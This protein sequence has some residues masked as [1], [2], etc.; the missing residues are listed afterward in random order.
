MTLSELRRGYVRRKGGAWVPK[1][2]RTRK[3]RPSTSVHAPNSTEGRYRRECLSGIAPECIHYESETFTIT[4]VCRREYTPDWVVAVPGFPPFYHEVKG[5]YKL[6]SENRARLAWEMAA[7][8][9]PN[10]VFVWAVL[11]RR[12]WEI[13]EWHDG[14]RMIRVKFAGETQYC[15]VD[16]DWRR[17]RPKSKRRA[18]GGAS[19]SAT[20][21]TDRAECGERMGLDSQITLYRRGAHTRKTRGIITPPMRF[22]NTKTCRSVEKRAKRPFMGV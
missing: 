10:A 6:G 11:T 12:G 20:A 19:A 7:E 16:A 22:V 17:H 4:K 2:Q 21:L 9:H 1:K 15:D 3:C 8:Q 14:G 13:E 18:K 5:A